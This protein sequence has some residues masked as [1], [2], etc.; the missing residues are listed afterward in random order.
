[1]VLPRLIEAHFPII[2]FFNEQLTILVKEIAH[3]KIKLEE[4]IRRY[5]ELKSAKKT[6]DAMEGL[7]AIVNKDIVLYFGKHVK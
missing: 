7:K 5:T 6:L 1:M 4:K 3:F 2:L